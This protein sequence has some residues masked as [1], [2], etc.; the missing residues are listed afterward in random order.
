MAKHYT[1]DTFDPI[2]VEAWLTFVYHRGPQIKVHLNRQAAL[3][4][5][6]NWRDGPSL[7][8]ESTP[9]GWVLRVRKVVDDHHHR[10]ERCGQPAVTSNP[11]GYLIHPDIKEGQFAGQ[12]S[13]H[14]WVWEKEP[15]KNRVSTPPR[16]WFLCKHCMVHMP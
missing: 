16:L 9:Q 7:L 12:F 6:S 13:N 5:I 10:C 1:V 11:K 4:A 15:G 14:Y 2:T 8:Y 3:G